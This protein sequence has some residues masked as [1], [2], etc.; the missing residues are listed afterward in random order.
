MGVPIPERHRFFEDLIRRFEDLPWVEAATVAENAPLSGH[1]VQ[2]VVPQTGEDRVTVTVARVWTGYFEVMEMDILR[3]RAFLVTDTVDAPGV[4]VVNESLAARL[5]A[6]GDAIGHILTWPGRG[7]EP[8]RRL[9]VV[10][11]V[12]DAKEVSLLDDPGP[13]AYFDLQ[14][15]YSRPGNALLVKVRGDPTPAVDAMRRELGDIDTRIAIVNILPYR[16]VVR[17][18]LY[19]QRMNAELFTVIAALGL[20]LAAAGVF[21]VVALSVTARTREIGIRMAIGADGASVARSVLGPISGSVLVGLGIGLAGA[22]LATRWVE[23]LLW[24]VA[25]ADPLALAAGLGVLL[26]AVALAVQIPLRRAIRID[27]VGCLRAE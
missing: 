18:S 6:D 17:G 5:A 10:G 21:A 26:I 20:L 24:G 19:A 15:E 27:P 22:F 11:V 8:D 12:R 23:S 2:E 3:G 14:Q 13:V 7:E 25:P 1:P 9:E 4:V 16:D